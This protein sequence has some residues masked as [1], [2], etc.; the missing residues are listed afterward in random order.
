MKR[1]LDQIASLVKA[2]KNLRGKVILIVYNIFQKAEDKVPYLV[3][4]V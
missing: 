2:T 4:A 3:R 1:T